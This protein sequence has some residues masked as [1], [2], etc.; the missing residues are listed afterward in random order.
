MPSLM[1]ITDNNQGY[2]AFIMFIKSEHF[3]TLHDQ[4][5]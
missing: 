5:I 2:K 4:I 1:L 3:V